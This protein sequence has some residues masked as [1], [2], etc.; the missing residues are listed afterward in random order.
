M[1]EFNGGGFSCGINIRST[2]ALPAKLNTQKDQILVQVNFV[3]THNWE[4]MIELS[5]MLTCRM[6]F[7]LTTGKGSYKEFV[8]VVFHS[9]FS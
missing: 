4:S 8:R 7:D 6:L 2:R 3:N 9:N 1:R 5:S